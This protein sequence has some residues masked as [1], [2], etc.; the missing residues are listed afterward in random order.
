M[1]NPRPELVFEGSD[2]G[3]N[4]RADEFP[5]KPGDLA[6]RPTWVAPFQ[7]RLDWQLWFAALGSPANR[8]FISNAG[9]IVRRNVRYV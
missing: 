3:R 2:D 6:R 4:W 5:D 7:P 9:F 8:N 1:T